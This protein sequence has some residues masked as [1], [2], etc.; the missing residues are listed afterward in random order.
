MPSALAAVEL[1]QEASGRLQ[2]A[3][4][5]LAH[6]AEELTDYMAQVLWTTSAGHPGE[7][8]RPT[9]VSRAVVVTDTTNAPRTGSTASQATPQGLTPDQFAWALPTAERGSAH[10]GGE[11]STAAEQRGLPGQTVTSTSPSE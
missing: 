6:S 11:V 9:E 1:S 2:A 8:I 10:I 5:F 7:E 4:T 3:I